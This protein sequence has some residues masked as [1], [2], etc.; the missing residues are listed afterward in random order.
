MATETPGRRTWGRVLPPVGAGLVLVGFVAWTARAPRP[1][2]DPVEIG[3]AP[4]VW[5]VMVLAVLSAAVLLYVRPAPQRRPSSTAT[6]LGLA[7][8]LAILLL[9][10]WL[11][12]R[13]PVP[14]GWFGSEPAAPATPTVTPTPVEDDGGTTPSPVTDPATV[15]A[16][17]VA[18]ALLGAALLV[19][20]S[21][22]RP[23]PQAPR[24]GARP[25]DP[26]IA[27]L[28][29]PAAARTPA[30]AVCAAYAVGRR[31][32]APETGDDDPTAGDRA[33]L[34][35]ARQLATAPGGDA[36]GELT[37]LYL[38][39]RYGGA[40]ASDTDRHAA[41]DALTRITAAVRR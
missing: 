15:V 30:E 5:G 16:G 38:P 4:I 25:T 9:L 24:S 27:T 18:V 33:P 23:A 7:R 8:L 34:A 19:R 10:V 11:I 6:V 39:I 2:G 28:P 41:L 21:T 3:L 26:R 31:L 37:G 20:R 14:A 36:F 35:L 17:F 1:H 32:L 13:I 22:P 29:D 40:T 12:P